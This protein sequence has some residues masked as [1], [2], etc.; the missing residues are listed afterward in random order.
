MLQRVS[1]T[2]LCCCL[3]G[4]AGK[5]HEVTGHAPTAGPAA[6][7]AQ[8]VPVHDDAAP[9][10][11]APAGDVAP[12]PP[13]A[14][15]GAAAA[16]AGDKR[17]TFLAQLRAV[18]GTVPPL[19][20]KLDPPTMSGGMIV[21]DF[22]IG[23]TPSW[24]VPGTLR[25]PAAATGK[26]P[27]LICLHATGSDR[28]AGDVVKITTTMTGRGFL[29][30][31][32]SGRYFGKGGGNPA[33]INALKAAYAS[34]GQD[35]PF[36]Y[37]T[38]WDVMRTIDYLVT[39]DDVD[40][41]RIGLTGISKGGMETFLAAAVDPRVAASAPIIGVQSFKWGLENNA[42]QARAE[43]L[44]GAVPNPTNAMSVRQFYDRVAPGL[45]D[46]Y[47]GPDMLPLIA[48]RPL[49]VLSG[50]QDPRNAIHGVEL[51]IAAARTAYGA[52]GAPDHLK[53]FPANVGHDGGY[54][55]FH[56][57]AMA[58]I[59]QWLTTRPTVPPGPAPPAGAH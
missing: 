39:R 18:V 45:V 33:Y 49:I 17:A 28:N 4:C 21:Q 54:L 47:D 24:R 50:T 12:P 26:L 30:V 59:E 27:V 35:Y 20:P 40:P 16:P 11:Q 37:D 51:A 19:D 36:L 41:D 8:S 55:P 3:A 14:A 10:D 52:A 5:S 34:P 25:R 48:P 46:L 23:S 38:V 15:D 56:D 9:P 44:G 29:T 7:D 42:F 32:I 43:S 13:V 57:Q 22:T 6:S 53:Y 2:V 1:R 31:A 58:W